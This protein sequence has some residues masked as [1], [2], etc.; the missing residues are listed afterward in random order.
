[1][2]DHS[3]A[4]LP[5]MDV[6]AGRLMAV[7]AA[8]A[9]LLLPGCGAARR[10]E[11]EPGPTAVRVA[12]A[13]PASARQGVSASGTAAYE[14]QSTLSFRVGGVISRLTVDM[15][16]RI[17][18]G[19]PLARIAGTDIQ[20]QLASRDAELARATR[21][22]ARLEA[23]A[24]SG[25]VASAAVQDQRDTVEQA[26]AAAAAARYDQQSATLVSPF[27][28][29]VLERLSQLGETVGAGQAIL[30][31]AD[32]DSP[33]VIR[34]PL[35]ERDADGIA[36]GTPAEVRFEGR[37]ALAGRVA[38]SQPLVDGAT[39]TRMVEVRLPSGGHGQ[40]GAIASVRFPSSAAPAQ[41]SLAA[42]PAEAFVPRSGREGGV[43][44]V[45][46]NGRARFVRLRLVRFEA[47]DAVVAG[48]SPG[49]RVV[50]AGAGYLKDG[51]PVLVAGGN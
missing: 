20:Q 32:Y 22:L 24:Q 29:V 19:Q 7:A 13:A 37:Q 18:V 50:T 21:T 3:P 12:L 51:D 6:R 39:G 48:L 11:A 49:T 38:K 34:V 43:F 10:D 9:A 1:M 41:P 14:R 40:S 42:V 8:L 26:R 4:G 2:T 15:G 16:S 23:L 46:A 30:R 17:R 47:D 45:G 35:A 33:L 5:A 25:S 27:S 36:I 31:V 28:G 44:T